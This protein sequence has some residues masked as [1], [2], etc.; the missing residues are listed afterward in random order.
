MKKKNTPPDNTGKKYEVEITPMEENF[1]DIY[2]S[3]Y[4]KLT[5]TECAIQA[6]YAKKSAH[7]RAYELL[8]W[9]IYPRVRKEIDKRLELTRQEWE[10]DRDKHLANLYRIGRAAE[11]KGHFGVVLNAEK[12]RGMVGG[13][14]I[15]K[16][17]NLNKELTEDE[18]HEKWKTIFGSKEDFMKGSKEIAEEVFAEKEDEKDDK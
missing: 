12:L 5:A 17:M 2:C 13:L 10:V 7:T 9:K 18:I 16:T 3:N 4:G 15:E 1:I 8:N 11:S 6:G 14:Y